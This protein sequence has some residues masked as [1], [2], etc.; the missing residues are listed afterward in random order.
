[1]ID[2]GKSTAEYE[3]N[4]VQHLFEQPIN[5]DDITNNEK[6]LIVGRKGAGKSSYIDFMV[7]QSNG[8]VR[9]VLRPG[10][11]VSNAVLG[12][13]SA[14]KDKIKAENYELLEDEVKENMI[15]VLDL[16]FH[17]TVMNKLYQSWDDKILTGDKKTI[18]DFLKLHDLIDGSSIYKGIKFVRKITKGLEKLNL[19]S[20]LLSNLDDISYEDATE[21]LYD[22]L[23]RTETDF[24][25]Y[26]DNIDD[27]GFDFTLR[28]RAYYNALLALT[29]RVNGSAIEEKIPLRLVLA[30]PSE[31]YETSI[32]WNQ[33]KVAR[34]TAYIHWED[35]EKVKNLL[36]KRIAV[37]LNIRKKHPRWKDDVYS[38][39]SEHTW[40]KLFKHII[41]NKLH[42]D[43]DLFLYVLRHSLYT[44][45]TVLNLCSRILVA[46]FDAGLSDDEMI[47]SS[48]DKESELVIHAIEQQTI[49]ISKGIISV[50]CKLY[51]GFSELLTI[52][53][54]N[55]NIYS[56][57][58]LEEVIDVYATDLMKDITTNEYINDKNKIIDILYRSGVI[59]FGRNNYVNSNFGNEYNLYF[60][61]VKASSCGQSWDC[62]LISPIFY[63]YLAVQREPVT[64]VEPHK[65][66][67]L[68]K[69]KLKRWGA[70]EKELL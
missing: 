68:N 24:T 21:A 2:L 47:S 59:G 36:N 35:E 25:L 57:K 39:A 49:E 67:F 62:A 70:L 15:I 27:F 12:I 38:V 54:G 51:P 63:D 1:M 48:K 28:N 64:N 19:I 11:R 3:E 43:E 9:E 33:D 53:A 56:K 20:Q 46:K 26:I 69:E 34:R 42:K 58:G 52:F 10:K 65:K 14:L 66:L 18:Y 60:S 5:F 31:L 8:K 30:I 37:E 29:M 23:R 6:W 45:R 50:F 32:L 40:D 55:I 7:S 22:N 16:I 41:S 61:Y 13:Y 4:L 44:P 17:I